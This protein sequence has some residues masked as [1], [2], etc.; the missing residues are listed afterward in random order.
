MR[1]ELGK[2]EENVGFLASR[3]SY[4]AAK[5]ADRALDPFGLSTKSYALLE[6]AAVGEG[7]SQR[8]LGRILCLDPSRV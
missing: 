4:L 7:A 1:G 2:L 3:F 8:E 6:L 5:R